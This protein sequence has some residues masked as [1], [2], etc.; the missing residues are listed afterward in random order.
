M[1]FVSGHGLSSIPALTCP[2][3]IESNAV[4]HPEKRQTLVEALVKDSNARRILQVL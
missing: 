4:H 1:R 3:M 2:P